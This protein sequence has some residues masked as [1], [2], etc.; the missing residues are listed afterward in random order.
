MDCFSDV[1]ECLS[2]V[3]NTCEQVCRN[4]AGGFSCSCNSGFNVDPNDNTKCIGEACSCG[5]LTIDK[6][7]A[8]TTNLNNN[9]F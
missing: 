4:T 7:I 8:L 1:D 3:L 9:K 5:N 6:A 2:S